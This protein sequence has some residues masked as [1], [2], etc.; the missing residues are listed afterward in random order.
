VLRQHEDLHGSSLVTE[1]VVRLSLSLFPVIADALSDLD[2]LNT[3]LGRIA[4]TDVTSWF[5]R[6]CTERGSSWSA[7]RSRWRSRH[8]SWPHLWRSCSSWASRAARA[9]GQYIAYKRPPTGSLL[10]EGSF[11]VVIAAL[12][13]DEIG[14]KYMIGPMMLGL[15]LPGGMPIGAADRPTGGV[16]VPSRSSCSTSPSLSVTPRSCS[17]LTALLRRLAPTT[18]WVITQANWNTKW[19]Q[20]KFWCGNND[21]R[22]FFFISYI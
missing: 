14:F 15:A 13:T 12:V 9:A 17:S 6:A 3:H 8:R 10:S 20:R 16:E 11:V 19:T 18:A 2:L 5:L 21:H 4:L 7:R 22:V 1:L